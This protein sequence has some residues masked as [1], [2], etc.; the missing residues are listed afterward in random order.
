MRRFAW[1]FAGSLL[2]DVALTV[3]SSISRN[4]DQSLWYA[5]LWPAI[6]VAMVIGGVHSAGMFSLAIGFVVTAILY[7]LIVLGFWALISKLI[8]SNR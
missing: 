7:S 2:L 1:I 6:W 8:P 3:S 4:S 5:P